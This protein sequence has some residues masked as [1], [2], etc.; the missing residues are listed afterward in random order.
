MWENVDWFVEVLSCRM[1]C[2]AL[3]RIRWSRLTQHLGSQ[4]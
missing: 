4:L 1:L 2:V 3:R